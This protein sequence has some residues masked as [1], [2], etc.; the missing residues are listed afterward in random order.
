MAS[1][2][3]ACRLKFFDQINSIDAKSLVTSFNILELRFKLLGFNILGMSHGPTV[4]Q[5][6]TNLRYLEVLDPPAWL[7]SAFGS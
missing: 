5:F 2:D 6:L 1:S 4:L 3:R 7:L